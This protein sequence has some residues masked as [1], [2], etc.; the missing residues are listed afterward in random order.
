ML[1]SYFKLIYIGLPQTISRVFHWRF[2]TKSTVISA[3]NKKE[4]ING[5]SVHPSIL[6]FTMDL[7]LKF[8]SVSLSLLKVIRKPNEPQYP[9]H[10]FLQESSWVTDLETCFMWTQTLQM[11]TLSPK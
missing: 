10:T 7:S 8:Y 11:I 1:F 9:E 3:V 2:A 6:D 5:I 4:S